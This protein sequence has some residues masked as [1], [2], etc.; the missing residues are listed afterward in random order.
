MIVISLREIFLFKEL[1]MSLIVR[2]FSF[3][4]LLCLFFTSNA[5]AIEINEQGADK[6]RDQIQQQIADWQK[7][8][9]SQNE[10]YELDFDGLLMVEPVDNSY[11]AVTFPKIN[12]LLEK[13]MKVDIGMVAANVIPIEAPYENAPEM[14]SV[15]TALPTPWLL[16]KGD[17][18]TGRL[19]IGQQQ[20]TYLWVPSWNMAVN[21]NM[22]IKD[23]K[24]FDFE[25][26]FKGAIQSWSHK[27]DYQPTEKLN[28][29]SEPLWA[30]GD[31]SQMRGLS[32]LNDDKNV[33]VRVATLDY[34]T[35]TTDFDFQEIARAAQDLEEFASYKADEQQMTSADVTTVFNF[36]QRLA[37]S[38]GESKGTFS[39]KDIY[40][41]SPSQ[42]DP[43]KIDEFKMAELNSVSDIS[44][45]R[46]A[47]SMDMINLAPAGGELDPNIQRFMPMDFK[48]AYAMEDL[49]EWEQ[50]ESLMQKAA[51][52][53]ELQT[54]YNAEQ[55]KT[56][57]MSKCKA[58]P[59]TKC[60]KPNPQIKAM[61][62]QLMQEALKTFQDA[63]TKIEINNFL[64]DLN[65][66][67]LDIQGEGQFVEGA[68]FGAAGVVKVFLM[69]LDSLAGID[70]SALPDAAQGQGAMLQQAQGFL[71]M[72]Q[73][74]GKVV[75][76]STTGPNGETI[77]EKRLYEFTISKEGNI[78]MNGNDLSQMMGMMGGAPKGV[79]Q[80]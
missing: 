28:A 40:V 20:V 46:F 8:I 10:P 36:F 39:V 59:Q 47:V 9:K 26:G 54:Q 73:M 49:P 23:I 52:I 50:F 64:F 18:I 32:I 31:Q 62:D 37:G 41:K 76:P 51:K 65:Q 3:V 5:H 7:K 57:D 72:L 4:F 15:A 48:I 61:N 33:E 55:M 16:Q 17:K 71:P 1:N 68:K 35:Q 58:V 12:M 22:D 34:Q 30:G 29:N 75:E 79:P 42:N 45:N 2:L 67:A 44:D 74:M 19:S 13:D 25:N 27:S 63:G 56:M 38:Y 24:F 70:T 6:L 53:D 43:T 14:W 11:Y 78:A 77:P 60:I 80:Q 66:V 21:V 69:G